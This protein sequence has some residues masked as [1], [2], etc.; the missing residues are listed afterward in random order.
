MLKGKIHPAGETFLNWYAC[1][2]RLKVIV[3]K[4][5]EDY[6]KKLIN[7]IIILAVLCPSPLNNVSD[8]TANLLRILTMQATN[9]SQGMRK[10]TEFII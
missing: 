2:N 9:I 4:N 7:F 10:G 1:I 3:S 5:W 6:K 8:N